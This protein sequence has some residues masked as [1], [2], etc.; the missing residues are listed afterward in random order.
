VAPLGFH[1]IYTA[2][3]LVERHGFRS[4]DAV[5]QDQLPPAA[6]AA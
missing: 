3:W 6:L 5:R 4:P 2:T 1:E